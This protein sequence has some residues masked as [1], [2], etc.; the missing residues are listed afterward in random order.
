MQA[1]EKTSGYEVSILCRCE[2][3][4]EEGKGVATMQALEQARG[5]HML[6]NATAC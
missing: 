2:A 1:E 6:H 4:C 5:R 3:V